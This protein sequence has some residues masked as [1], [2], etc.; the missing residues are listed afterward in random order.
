MINDFFTQEVI[1]NIKDERGNNIGIDIITYCRG[2][3]Q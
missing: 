1:E 3:S 2:R